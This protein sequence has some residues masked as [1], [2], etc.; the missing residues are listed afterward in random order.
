MKTYKILIVDDE[1][2]N[3]ENLVDAIKKTEKNFNILR[4]NSAKM[5]LRILSSD[6]PDIIISDWNMPEMNGIELIRE[7]KANEMTA[8]IPVIMCSG[9]MTSSQNL[10]AALD[11]GAIDY[12]RKPVDYV[13]L[14]AR[15]NAVLKLSESY[16]TIKKL[17]F[18]KDKLFNIIAHDLRN[19]FNSI[20][21][22]SDLL[23]QNI[24]KYDKEE[25]K[26]FV[27]TINDEG[28]NTFKLLE[29]LLAWARS[30]QDNIP[31][32]PQE[33][34]LY[35]L[36]YET[37]IL[38]NHAASKKQIT[39]NLDILHDISFEADS[40][41]IKTVIRNL[42][43]NAIK[44]TP[45]NGLINI[46][47]EQVGNTIIIQISDTGTGMNEQ[48]LKSLFRIG[49]TKSQEGTNGEQG[50]GFGLLLCKEF[51]DKHN[52]TIQVESELNKGSN[53]IISIPIIN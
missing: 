13:E 25:I 24:E 32:N 9:V 50:T 23:I 36:A 43:S 22:L 16:K 3:L 49:E 41:M 29:N 39:I 27:K 28:R 12:I 2:V 52:G 40:E 14:E 33:H 18:T 4:A 21:G 10:K 42:V 7:I 35:N 15:V 11:A 51:V 31:F 38:V 47:G 30:Q 46:L 8:D 45:E 5:A 6:T 1:L 20:L 26:R 34:K 19:P 44:Y 48:T 37:Y 17:N 53:F